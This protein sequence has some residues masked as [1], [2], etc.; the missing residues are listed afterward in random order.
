MPTTP[1]IVAFAGSLRK[2]SWNKSLVRIAASGAQAA[3]AEVTLLNL[4]DFPLPIFNQDEEQDHGLPSNARQLKDLLISHHGMLIASPEY[5]SSI[6]AVLKN[7]IDWVSRPVPGEP[8]MAAFNNKAA[9][10]ISASPGALGGLRGLVHLRAILGNI[11]VLVLPGTVSVPKANE[12]FGADG[13]LLDAGL[14]A[15]VQRLGAELAGFLT[16]HIQA[17]S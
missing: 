10:L 9:T 12:A 11:G 15:R 5:N 6:T 16:R 1:K 17:A 13:Q 8:P 7:T 2:D 4:A 3:G 14:Q